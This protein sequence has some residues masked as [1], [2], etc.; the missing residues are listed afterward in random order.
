MASESAPSVLIIR[1]QRDND[2]LVAQLA[3]T[4]YRVFQY[5]V[6]TICPMDPEQLSAR[7]RIENFGGYHKAIF[8]SRQA[9]L[10]G[11]DWLGRYWPQLPEGVEYFCVGDS[12]AQPL[13]ER[14]LAV[15]VPEQ[16]ASSE[17]L[18]ALP[19]LQ[20]VAGQRVLIVR[21]EGGRTL[22]SETLM[23]RGA[24]VDYCDLYRRVIDAQHAQRLQH[25]LASEAVLLVVIH[26]VDLLSALVALVGD[27]ASSLLARHVVLTP[28]ERVAQQVREAGQGTVLVAGSALT[29]DM[30]GE[31]RRWYTVA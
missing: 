3:A 13:R 9:A 15:T 27:S 6:I 7:A 22:L 8:V 30:V 14:G 31:I 28:S 4:G 25:L 12:T 10:L 1:P 11:L 19:Q 23:A 18:L 17:A 5:P 21:G 16:G 26:S 20:Q 2:P 24:H 29:I